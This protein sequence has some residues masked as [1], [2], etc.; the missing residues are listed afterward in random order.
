M[1]KRIVVHK[2][3]INAFKRRALKKYPNEYGEIILGKLSDNDTLHI[4]VFDRLNIFSATSSVLHYGMPEEE[5]C[6][7]HNLD[8]FGVI[9]THINSLDGPSETDWHFFDYAVNEDHSILND[10]EI[11]TLN[12]Y[13][14]GILYLKK[15]K[16]VT[17][18][19][20]YF[21]N[22]NHEPIEIIYSE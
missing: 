4:Y 5:V 21:Y 14:I 11:T 3:V 10:E 16:N 9:H 20:L 1:I 6:E 2:D 7:G 8:F 18:W 13:V 17:H 12:S 22:I 15:L 19:S